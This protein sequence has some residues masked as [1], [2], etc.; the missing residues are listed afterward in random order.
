MVLRV[1]SAKKTTTVHKKAPSSDGALFCLPF[2][3]VAGVGAGPPG[4]F[5]SVY[6]GFPMLCLSYQ[7]GE[8]SSGVQP[9]VVKTKGMHGAGPA[10]GQLQHDAF[11]QPCLVLLLHHGGCNEVHEAHGN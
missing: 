5:V 1:H 9:V 8:V 2:G 4:V 6:A 10:A 3:R 11:G 7:A